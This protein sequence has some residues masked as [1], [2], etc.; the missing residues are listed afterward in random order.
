MGLLKINKRCW[1]RGMETSTLRFDKQQQSIIYSPDGI[2][3]K[4]FKQLLPHFC[5]R[6]LVFESVDRPRS[7]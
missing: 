2:S 7:Q 1:F 4:V 5:S 6:F 3:L